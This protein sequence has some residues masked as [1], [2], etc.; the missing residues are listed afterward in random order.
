MNIGFFI[1]HFLERGTEVSAYDYALYNE[2]ILNNKSYIICFSQ[3]KQSSLGAGFPSERDSY[4]KFASR[5]RIIEI[6]DI[7]EMSNITREYDLSFFYTLTHGGPGD[8]YQFESCLKKIN[9]IS[10]ELEIPHKNDFK[11]VGIGV[12]NN[13]GYSDI[14]VI[15]F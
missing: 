9:N 8:I 2:E 10:W 13:A 4:D 5:F 12:S 3:Q 11:K 14:K 6:N 7:S 1:R 15:T